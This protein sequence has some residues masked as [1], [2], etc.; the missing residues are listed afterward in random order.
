LGSHA[1]AALRSHAEKGRADL[2]MHAVSHMVWD[3]PP[4][5]HRG[6][7][8]ADEILGTALHHGASVFWAVVFEG[9]FGRRVER[10][11]LAALSGGASTAIT[12]YVIDYHVVPDRYNPGFHA[13]LS[14]RSLFL[15]YAGLALGLAAGARLRG[16]HHHQIEDRDERDK[17]RDAERSPDAVVTPE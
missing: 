10:S 16:L 11:T 1:V 15:V 12:A 6:R 3:D 13:H 14:S 17:R 8:T 9:L 2:P 7:R 4:Q 5:S